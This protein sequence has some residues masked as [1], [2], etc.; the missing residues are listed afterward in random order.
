MNSRWADG[1]RA[2]NVLIK[3]LVQHVL[4]FCP[5][6]ICAFLPERVVACPE[7][8]TEKRQDVEFAA[9]F[10]PDGGVLGE[11]V[12]IRDRCRENAGFKADELTEREAFQIPFHQATGKIIARLGELECGTA[13]DDEPDIGKRVIDVLDLLYP[14]QDQVGRYREFAAGDL[15][16]GLRASEDV[17]LPFDPGGLDL[18]DPAV[19]TD[20]LFG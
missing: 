4:H 20:E 2:R 8:F 13:G 18:L 5:V 17:A 10:R 12:L 15:G 11:Q 1:E 19:G 14:N 9:Q 16:H 7:V 3:Y 6:I